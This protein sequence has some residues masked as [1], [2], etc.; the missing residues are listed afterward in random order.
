MQVSDLGR[1]TRLAAGAAGATFAVDRVAKVAIE[2]GLGEGQRARGPL[3]IHLRRTTNARPLQ[4]GAPGGGE[5]P[6][7]FAAAWTWALGV[8]A[9]GVAARRPAAVPIG[10]GIV[11]GAMAANL[12]DRAAGRGTTASMTSPLGV[13]H[14]AD[15]ALGAGFVCA[16]LGLMV[17]R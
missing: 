17:R 4:G 14:L 9:A 5:S 10:A 3:G 15:L 11:A 2:H 7:L 8:G 12:L 13:L 6:L 16:G 1:A